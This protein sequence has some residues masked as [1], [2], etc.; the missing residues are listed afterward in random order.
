MQR[1]GCLF[2]GTV[3]RF[4]FVHLTNIHCPSTLSLC[5]QKGLHAMDTEVNRPNGYLPSQNSQS[6]GK[7]NCVLK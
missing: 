2:Y 7:E 6:T 3:G 1:T 5:F 4:S